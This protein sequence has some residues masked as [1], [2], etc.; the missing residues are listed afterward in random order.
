[1]AD[2]ATTIARLR[3]Q[4]EGGNDG[5]WGQY[6][7]VNLTLLEDLAAGVLSKDISGE[8]NITLT[9]TNFVADEARH[10]EAVVRPCRQLCLGLLLRLQPRLLL[11]THAARHGLQLLSHAQWIQQYSPVRHI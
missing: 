10:A 2:S 3:N 5:L 7:D 9:S 8:G 1:M 4:E 6:T 11:L